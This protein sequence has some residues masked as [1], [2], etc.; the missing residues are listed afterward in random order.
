MLDK[1]VLFAFLRVLILLSVIYY[2]KQL[3]TSFYL[4]GQLKNLLD[5]K[6]REQQQLLLE[7]KRQNASTQCNID[8]GTTASRNGSSNEFLSVDTSIY[9]PPSS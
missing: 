5:H 3:L 4:A 8:H 7:L 1:L 2:S 6:I 9:E